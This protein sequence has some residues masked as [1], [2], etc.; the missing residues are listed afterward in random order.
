MP[1]YVAEYTYLP[2][3]AALRDEHRPA[4]RLWLH[5]GHEAGI[6][7]AVGAFADGSGALVIVNAD[8]AEAAAEVLAHDPFALVGAID[9]TRVREWNC[10]YGPF[11]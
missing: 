9:E 3:T 1:K 8:D 6:V 11:A 4:H 10:L 7:L 5:D 2:D